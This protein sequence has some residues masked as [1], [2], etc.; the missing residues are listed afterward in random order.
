MKRNKRSLKSAL[1]AIT[2]AGV[3]IVSPSATQAAPPVTGS[4][5]G[6]PVVATDD[7]AFVRLLGNPADG[8]VKFQFGWMKST[9]AS[10]AAGYWIGLYDVTRSRYVWSLDTGP[11]DL[12]DQFFRNA[13]PTPYL[14][15]GK[16][17]VNFFVRET[18]SEPVSNISE[19]E[20]P[21]TVDYM[22]D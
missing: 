3:G 12:P 7:G 20:L 6:A 15:D 2:I 13:L 8:T 11:I 14:E 4:N 9:P 21:F 5:N 16:Y 17:K 1:L 19:I 22:E 18:Y 10:D